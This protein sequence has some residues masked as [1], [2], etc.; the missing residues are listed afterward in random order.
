MYCHLVKP[1]FFLHRLH[2]L[3]RCVDPRHETLLRKHLTSLPRPECS[4]SFRL[5]YHARNIYVDTADNYTIRGWHI[6]PSHHVRR[7]HAAVD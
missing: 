4:G 5:H 7:H 3:R 2:D 6:L 1:P